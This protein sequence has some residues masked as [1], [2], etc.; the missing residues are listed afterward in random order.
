MSQT[1]RMNFLQDI[2]QMTAI[3]LVSVSKVK[4]SPFSRGWLEGSFFH[5][6]YTK[7]LGAL[8]LS[9]DCSTL[10]LIFIL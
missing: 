5:S 3:V 8:L 9:L 4:L 6:Y 10:L 2:F 1:Q 7:A